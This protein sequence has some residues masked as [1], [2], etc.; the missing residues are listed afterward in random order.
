MSKLDSFSK[1]HVSLEVENPTSFNFSIPIPE[2]SPSTPIYGVGK[3]AESTTSQT[4]V[5]GSPIFLSPDNLVCS[6]TL[7]ESRN[8][9][10]DSGAQSVAKPLDDLVSEVT[11]TGSMAVSS[12]MSER[13][14]EGDLPEGTGP[15]S[16]ILTVGAEL[17]AV[18][19]LASLRGDVQ[20]NLI[21]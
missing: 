10:Q 2:E 4:E 16:Y 1:A 15:A 3:M 21:D 9:S 11:K 18:Q 14:F 8:K 17:V 7:V 5:L 13:L 12:T 20:T 19:S 6:P